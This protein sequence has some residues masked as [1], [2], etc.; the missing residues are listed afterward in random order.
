MTL[1]KPIR[2]L[3]VDDHLMVRRGLATFLQIF[4]DLELVGE[5]SD[6]EMALQLCAAVQP[7]VVLMDIMMPEMGG[8][9]A[10][11]LIRQRFPAVQVIALTSFK[12]EALVQEAL[13]A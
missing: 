6:G 9:A 5:A 8:I 1:S 13:Q 11:R 7:N 10:T 12:E 3:I 4:D 2:V